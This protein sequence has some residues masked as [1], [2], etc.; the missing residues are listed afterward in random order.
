MLIFKF[1]QDFKE[2]RTFSFGEKNQKILNMKCFKITKTFMWSK[3]H[4]IPIKI[5][6]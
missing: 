4:N 3:G 5:Q 1:I 6:E 2:N